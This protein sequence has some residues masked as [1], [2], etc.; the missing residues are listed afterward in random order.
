M[1]DMRAPVVLTGYETMVAIKA[2]SKFANIAIEDGVV[3]EVTKSSITV[4]Y[5]TKGKVTYKLYSWTSKE[6]S[7]AC[8]THNMVTALE[9]GT[10]FL[11]DD[12]ITYDNFFFEPCIFEPRRVIYKQGT[13]INVMLS[14][15]TE[16]WEDSAAIS[17]NMQ[18]KLGTTLTKV[19][20]IVLNKNE[21]IANLINIDT[22][23]EPNTSLLTILSADMDVSN[24]KDERALSILKDLGS[25]S[26]KAKVQGTI[27]KILV[28]YNFDVKDPEISNSVRELINYSDK[29]LLKNFNYT[30]R[31]TTG[32]NIQGVPLQPDQLVIKIYITVKEKMGN[33]DKY[34]L[35][36]QLKCTVGE[37]FDYKM[38]TESGREIDAV[39]SNR[40]IL[41]RIVNSPTLVGSTSSVIDQ[42]EKN[43]VKM[44]F[45]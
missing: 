38:T 29:I 2:G 8:Y 33:G 5:K 9:V 16:T 15:D 45:G 26:P 23:V 41:A 35:G 40:S 11:K 21:H 6:E 19:K 18:E 32:Y 42:I 36:S 22:K 30:G 7:E 10:K 20:S 4:E 12:T 24:I 13:M 25:V 3:K 43:V 39:F 37:V 17:K 27:D 31:V 44:Y 1:N 14:E 34:I 28:Y